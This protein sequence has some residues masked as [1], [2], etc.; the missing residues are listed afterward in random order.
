MISRM[1]PAAE[2]KVRFSFS[3]VLP[4][5]SIEAKIEEMY[6]SSVSFLERATTKTMTTDDDRGERT[7]PTTSQGDQERL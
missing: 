3:N 6:S 5:C 7:D 4:H 2:A 1:R